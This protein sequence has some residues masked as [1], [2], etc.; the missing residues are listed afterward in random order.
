VSKAWAQEGHDLLVES[1]YGQIYVY[2][3]GLTAE[4]SPNTQDTEDDNQLLR[5]LDDAFDTRRFVG[6]DTGLVDI[7]TPSQYNPSAPVR[8]EVGSGPPPLALDEWEHATEVPLPVPSGRIV[9]E[10]SGGGRQIETSVPPAV[11]RARISARG[12]R[13]GVGEIEGAEEY[14]IQLWPEPEGE[15]ALLKSWPGWDSMH[16]AG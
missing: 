16:P 2:D 5:A 15:P 12:Y 3:P 1:D 9:F 11:Y 13:S 6:Y 10:A 7:L 14:L 4:A 8:L